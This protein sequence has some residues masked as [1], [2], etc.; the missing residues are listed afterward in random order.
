MS[1]DA[2]R[3]LSPFEPFDLSVYLGPD[4]RPWISAQSSAGFVHGVPRQASDIPPLGELLDLCFD[5]TDGIAFA[6]KEPLPVLAGV[7]GTLVFG[8]AMVLQLFHATRGIAADR[9]CRLLLRILATPHLATLPWELLPDPASPRDAPGQRYLALAPDVQVVRLARGRAYS[10]RT[11]EL[12]P[13][14]NVLLVLSNPVFPDDAESLYDFDVFEVKRSLLQ[15]FAPLVAAGLLEVDVEDHP[16]VD[17][18]RR[19]VAS[20]QR[21]YHVFHYVGHA[22]PDR[23]ILEDAVG[24]ASELESDRLVE[25]LRLCPDLRLAVFAGCETARPQG[26][27]MGIEAAQA[28][29]WRDLL[30]LADRCVQGACPNVVGMQAVLPLST[31]RL[32]TRFLYQGLVSGYSLVDA[33]R[34]ARGAIQD[35]DRLG[36]DVLD[37]SVPVLFVGGSDRDA[38]PLMPRGWT[39]TPVQPRVATELKL[40]IRQSS[41]RF[42]ARELSLRQAVEVL[43]GRA[44]ERLLLVTG[45]HGTG[46]T[47]LIE[48]ALE[49]LRDDVGLVLFLH[50]SRLVPEVHE[51]CQAVEDP[52]GPDLPSLCALDPGIAVRRLCERANELL[53]RAERAPV[54]LDEGWSPNDWWE[55]VVGALVQAGCIVVVDDMGQIARVQA[56]LLR[57]VAGLWLADRV[58]ERREARVPAKQIDADVE[59]LLASL[60]QH[61]EAVAEGGDVAS[62]QLEDGLAQLADSLPVLPEGLR[63]ALPD[64]LLQALLE[65]V[66]PGDAAGV[67]EPVELRLRRY[68]RQRAGTHDAAAIQRALACLAEIRRC[69]TR[70]MEV[71]LSHRTGLR[72]ALTSTSRP[73]ELRTLSPD[74]IFEVRLANLT[75]GDTWRWLRR[76]L[77]GILRFGEQVL[78]RHWTRLGDRVELWEALERRVVR[79]DPRDLDLDAI[80]DELAPPRRARANPGNPSLLGRRGERPLRIAVAGPHLKGA[81]EMAQALTQLA[82]S[83]GV[84]GRVVTLVGMEAGAL[85]SIVEEPIAFDSDGLVSNAVVL[86]WLNRIARSRPDVVLLDYG[87]PLPRE[88]FGHALESDP[89]RPLLRRLA[90]GSLLIGAGGHFG[91]RATEV[92]TPGAYP[93]VLAIGPATAR[94]TLC[95]WSSW[96]EDLGKPD[97][98]MEDDLS[99]SPLG[100]AL[101]MPPPFAGSS[102]AAIHAVGAAVLAWS[103]LPELTPRGIR[104]VLEQAARPIA[105]AQGPRFLSVPLAVRHARRLLIGRALKSGPST[106]STLGAVTGLEPV[107]LSAT[108]QELRHEGVV[109]W[110][111]LGRLE[112]LRLVPQ[113][114]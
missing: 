70:A 37:W 76:S 36:G 1:D 40:G 5:Y 56:G 17:S 47:T 65:V 62:L 41:G 43:G 88:Q 78:A 42:L 67:E 100:S 44:A 111:Q 28:L 48:R 112:R 38:G 55:R 64:A 84:A 25:L 83:N 15:E 27:P 72:A 73:E 91:P 69:S 86:E 14:L 92:V 30:S 3:E 10:S 102:L 90:A 106:L 101:N 113:G 45:P 23:L 52:R 63:P 29:A 71:L 98:F 6:E 74:D 97:L 61:V 19:R 93:E 60:Q 26:D 77:P 110:V 81:V 12:Q 31:E 59:H 18:L 9:G 66:A 21:G 4:Q 2:G 99:V 33:V 105:A 50:T 96:T 107:T 114:R 51:A 89:Q 20:R 104:R 58:A 8:D 22:L 53:E 85:A 80:V 95:D 49:E 24:D 94:G 13:P 54:A 39:P 75:W 16:T 34:I 82:I 68:A 32:F 108:V 87:T 46:K 35:D 103:M 57:A 11:R 109:E 79:A 7:L